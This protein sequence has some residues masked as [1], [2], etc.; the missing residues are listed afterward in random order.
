MAWEEPSRRLPPPPPQLLQG[1]P[2]QRLDS[3]GREIDEAWT[4][5]EAER[6]IRG[7]GFR[8]SDYR[9]T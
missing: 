2:V 3:E 9:G 8:V 4:T 5:P 1:Q 6:G 7:T